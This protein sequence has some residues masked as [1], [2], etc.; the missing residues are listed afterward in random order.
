MDAGNY[1]A[2]QIVIF[3]FLL[4][5]WSDECKRKPSLL[6]GNVDLFFTVNV[7]SRRW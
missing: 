4:C 7:A 1:L 3:L 6:N 5:F 2:F